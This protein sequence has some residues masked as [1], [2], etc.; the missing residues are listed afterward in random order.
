MIGS[1]KGGTSALYYSIKTEADFCIIGAPQYHVGD[2]L[3]IATLSPIMDAIMGDHSENSKNRLN[4][5]IKD[6]IFA[7]HNNKPKI[8]IHYS[9]YEHTYKDHIEDMIIDLNK[10]GYCVVEDNKYYYQKHSDVAKY[11]PSYLLGTINSILQ[12]NY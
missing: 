4:N 7:S 1:S 3:S 8:Y 6:E 12:Q 10:A 2:Y 5:Y 11:F 9:P